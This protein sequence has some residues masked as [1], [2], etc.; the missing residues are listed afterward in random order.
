MVLMNEQDRKPVYLYCE[1]C[2]VGYPGHTPDCPRRIDELEDRK[3]FMK[4]PNA[5]WAPMLLLVFL[6][7]P[8]PINHGQA[9]WYAIIQA[10]VWITAHRQN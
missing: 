1:V 10:A 4:D 3:P 7:T 6:W 2:K 9:I 8:P 5:F